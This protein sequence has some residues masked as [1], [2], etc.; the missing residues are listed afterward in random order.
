MKPF[1]SYYGS[2][3]SMAKHYGKP[4]SE[5]VIEPFCGSAGYSTYWS[6]P[7]AH[8]YDLNPDIISIW[9]WLITASEQDIY[10][11][12]TEIETVAQINELPDGARQLIYM[13]VNKGRAEVGNNISSWY[14]KYK[15][16]TDC[17]VWGKPV[18][19]RL[20]SQIGMIR[21]WKA[22]TLDYQQI[23]NLEGHYHVDPPFSGQYGRR[24]PHS[25]INYEQLSRWCQ[26]RVGYVQVC[27]HADATWLPFKPLKESQTT[28]G[29]RSGK[30]FQEGIWTS[31]Q[32]N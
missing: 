17:K 30:T 3:W 8:L 29:K 9:N 14:F 11:L 27:E 13:W 24:Y 19:D 12:P 4:N 20:A 1:F 5:I 2:R 21:D 22:E 6:V 25:D 23:P 15:G 31:L 16:S 7:K 26:T 10:D 28:R 32:T 18:Q